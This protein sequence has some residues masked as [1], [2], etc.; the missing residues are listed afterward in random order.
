MHTH[1]S[2]HHG[3]DHHHHHHH[4]EAKD[5]SSAFWLNLS[6]TLIELIGGFFT[7]SLTILSDAVHDLGDSL[8][9]GMA[10]YFEK[11]ANQGKTQQ[12]TYGFQRFRIL[13][14][15]INAL[16]L[17]IGSVFILSEAIPRILNPVKPLAGWMIPIAIL[18]VL[19]NG[20]AVL[21]LGGSDSLNQKMVRLH[22][23][24]DAIGWILALIAALIMYFFHFP[25]IDPL[26]SIGL[27]LWLIF[28]TLRNLYQSISI[29]LQ[30]SPS[31]VSTDEAIQLIQ[32]HPQVRD[33]HDLH[34]WTMDGSYH[35]FS[36]HIVHQAGLAL[37]ELTEMKQALKAKLMDLGIGHVTLELEE[38]GED[39]AEGLPE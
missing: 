29:I 20:I 12:F 28:N 39:C 5:I 36:A 10:W 35:V 14:A 7:N 21:R 37:P 38:E 19:F 8:S 13:G 25:I 16:L 24:E 34:L 15:L 30:K 9:L 31:N 32:H 33:V 6:F 22:L 18:G 4:H 2:H 3:H 17:L 27:S 23:L 11:K 26:L 1:H